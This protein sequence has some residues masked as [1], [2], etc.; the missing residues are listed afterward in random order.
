[1]LGVDRFAGGDH[2]DRLLDADDAGQPLRAAPAGND[3]D[4]DFG[5]PDLGRRSVRGNAVI[6]GERDLSPATHAVAVDEGDGR[7]RQPTQAVKHLVTAAERGQHFF[8]G[9]KGQRGPF[10]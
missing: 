8:F 5:Q 7:E 2:L 4:F 1:M 6:H 3:A 9:G 10:P